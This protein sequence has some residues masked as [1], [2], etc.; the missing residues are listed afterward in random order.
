MPH[1]RRW[2]VYRRNECRRIGYGKQGKGAYLKCW[3]PRQRQ[4]QTAGSAEIVA[5]WG[6]AS[7]APT[8]DGDLGLQETGVWPGGPAPSGALSGAEE[9]LLSPLAPALLWRV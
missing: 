1:L 3:R 8:E 9:A 2:C 4:P 6:A 5:S 7:S